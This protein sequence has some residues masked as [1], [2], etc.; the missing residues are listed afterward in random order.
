MS[1]VPDD[2]HSKHSELPMQTDNSGATPLAL[3]M[4]LHPHK[5]RCGVAGQVA[6]VPP[7]PRPWSQR[8]LHVAVEKR[9][10][11]SVLATEHGV[12]GSSKHLLLFAAK[13][14]IR[15]SGVSCGALAAVA[16]IRGTAAKPQRSLGFRRSLGSGGHRGDHAR[17]ALPAQRILKQAR[18]L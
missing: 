16:D 1:S 15:A 12:S 11:V 10:F 17:Q 6:T 18:Q 7:L 4:R 8:N 14:R 2:L 3:P 5:S 13:Q 9:P